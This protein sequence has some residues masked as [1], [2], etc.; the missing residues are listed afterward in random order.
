MRVIKRMRDTFCPN[1]DQK[2]VGKSI[3]TT[4]KEDF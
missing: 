3:L 4:G 1:I 2:T